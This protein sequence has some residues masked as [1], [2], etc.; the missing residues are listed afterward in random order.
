MGSM[1]ADGVTV[2]PG[3][4]IIDSYVAAGQYINAEMNIVGQIIGN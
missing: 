2:G 4:K 3:A 1:L